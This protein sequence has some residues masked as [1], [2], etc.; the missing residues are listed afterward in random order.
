[1]E[2]VEF[3]GV[4]VEYDLFGDGDPVVLRTRGRS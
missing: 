3:D 2:H 1:M 4:R